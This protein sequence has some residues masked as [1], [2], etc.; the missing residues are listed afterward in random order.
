MAGFLRLKVVMRQLWLSYTLINIY[1]SNKRVQK[2]Q[3]WHDREA[4]KRKTAFKIFRE[5][6]QPANDYLGTIRFPSSFIL[7]SSIVV[8]TQNNKLGLSLV[9]GSVCSELFFLASFGRR[10][11]F[12]K[13]KKS[14]SPYPP[15]S[16]AVVVSWAVH[17]ALQGFC[18]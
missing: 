15:G 13:L 6:R 5:T 4:G 14:T 7:P 2:L 10:E 3:C 17:F 1:W 11:L 12:V 16:S 8:K 9:W 18:K